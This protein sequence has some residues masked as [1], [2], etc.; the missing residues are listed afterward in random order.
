MSQDPVR[1][2]L[3]DRAGDDA[4]AFGDKI[5][6]R[7]EVQLVGGS[8]DIDEALSEIRDTGPDIV[9]VGTDLAGL[10]AVNAVERVLMLSPD[11]AVVALGSS[12][13]KALFG[14]AIRA[15]AAGSLDRASNPMDTA[16]ALH[17]YKRRQAG[18]VVDMELAEPR[19][20]TIRV[21]GALPV[22]PGE[23]GGYPEP[24]VEAADAIRVGAAEVAARVAPPAGDSA[25]ADGWVPALAESLRAQA[26]VDKKAA[27]KKRFRLFGRGKDKA[28]KSPAP[29][30]TGWGP[31]VPAP[32]TKDKKR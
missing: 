30:S 13:D 17:V 25:P 32:G 20:P 12:S 9:L 23:G 10:G 31:A 14:A 18:E 29:S 21:S 15:G 28:A 11:A 3:I 5:G 6:R 26:L 16:T 4:N 7:P 27:K 24:G 1:V 22:F 2:Y 8:D 19:T